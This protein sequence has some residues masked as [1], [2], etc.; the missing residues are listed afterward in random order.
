VTAVPATATVGIAQ[1]LPVPG[2]TA[3]AVGAGRRL[4]CHYEATP[5]GHDEASYQ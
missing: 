5:S 1:W 2:E 4:C 3:A